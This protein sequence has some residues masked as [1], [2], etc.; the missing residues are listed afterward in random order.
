MKIKIV[1]LL[2][3]FIRT[4]KYS[5][6]CRQETVQIQG[7]YNRR[8]R[9]FYMV[10]QGEYRLVWSIICHF[11]YDCALCLRRYISR[12]ECRIRQLL[13]YD[14]PPIRCENVFAFSIQSVLLS[15]TFLLPRNLLWYHFLCLET[16]CDFFMLTFLIISLIF[17]INV[18]FRSCLKIR[19]ADFIN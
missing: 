1:P 14:T 4:T 15:A 9:M 13:C 3:S 12:K 16:N 5:F 17:F 10:G 2:S 18:T 19:N 11:I 7:T 6:V 8:T